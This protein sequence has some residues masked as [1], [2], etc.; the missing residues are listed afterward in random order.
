MLEYPSRCIWFPSVKYRLC[1]AVPS[2]DSAPQ[3]GASPR[4][5]ETSPVV[6]LPPY[7]GW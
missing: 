5:K 6:V 4:R 7:S 2:M 3:F 1:P